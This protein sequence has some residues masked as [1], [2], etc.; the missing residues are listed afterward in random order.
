MVLWRERTSR[1]ADTMTP[2]TGH[3]YVPRERNPF[4]LTFPREVNTPAGRQV[5]ESIFEVTPTLTVL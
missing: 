2:K 4:Y 1:P 5:A 3:T